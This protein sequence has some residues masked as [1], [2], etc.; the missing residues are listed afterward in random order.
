MSFWDHLDVLRGTLFRSAVCVVLISVVFFCFK[1]FLF[2]YI[3][4]APAR[5]D[6]FL[7]RWLKMPFEMTLINVDVTAQFMAHMKISFALGFIFSFPYIGYEVW[8]FIAPALYEGEKKSFRSAF[9][10]G[11]ILFYV[12]L[13]VGFYIIL[14]LALHF[15]IT[16][17][18]S[19][20]IHNTITLDSYIS[21][22]N[23]TILAFG[24]VFEFPMVIVIL[25]G[26]G[27]V[28]RS[29]MRRYR[30]HA[31]VGI[32]VVAA[33]VTPADPLSM[34]IA[35]IPLYLL[36]ELSVLLCKKKV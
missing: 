25:S 13:A 28:D 3:I 34:F 22:F 21:L 5:G 35:A 15:F 8:K 29:M 27:L 9:L 11:G 2:D 14:P 17:S 16:Y 6:F 31:I 4:F 32:L 36:Y 23:S 20:V 1:S 12:G 26:L 10:G 7:Y 19:D 24:I 18:V 30:K 33:L